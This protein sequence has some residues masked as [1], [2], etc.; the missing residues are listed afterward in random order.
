MGWRAEGCGGGGER[1]RIGRGLGEEG[2]RR[3][4]KRERRRIEKG[5]GER[6]GGKRG[7]IEW[8]VDEEREENAWG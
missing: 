8:E 4:E 1:R 6:E 7:I 5:E 3:R 2:R